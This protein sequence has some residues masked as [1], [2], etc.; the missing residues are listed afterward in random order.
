VV[1]K[2]GCQ[3]SPALACELQQFVK[4]NA[5]PHKYPRAV[6]FVEELPKTATGKIKRYRLRELAAAQ[7]PLHQEQG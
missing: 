1:L 5:A 7:T 6:E 2:D 3:P 4:K